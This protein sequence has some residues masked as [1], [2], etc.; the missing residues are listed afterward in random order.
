VVLVVVPA[1]E[2]DGVALAAALRQA[3]D[4]DE[5]IEALLRLRSQQLDVREVREVERTQR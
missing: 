2:I 5:E 1:A 4:V 3:H